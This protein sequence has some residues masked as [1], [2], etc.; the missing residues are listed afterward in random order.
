M[1]RPVPAVCAAL[2]FS[3]L[4]SGCVSTVGGSA[5]QAHGGGSTRAG[6]PKLEKSDLEH[7]LLT[8][9]A[10]NGIMDATGIRQTRTSEEMSDN[11][12]AVSDID[13]L[14]A[15]YGAEEKV[16]K[17][18][19]WTAVR[20]EVLQEP[21]SDNDHWVEQIAVLFP[22]PDKAQKFVEESRTTWKKCEG[23]S[24]DIDN[25]EVHSTWDIGDADTAGEIL[26]QSAEQR[27]AGG[28]GCQHALGTA[29]HLV[30]EAWACSN[31]IGDEAGSIA[32]EML[33]NAAKKK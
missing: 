25:D 31:S 2:M 7:V 6:G 22:S 27:D 14:G 3:A 9:G 15:I 12:D 21:V 28:W 33:R 24:I 26:T 19:D 8:A 1:I 32:T 29:S 5:V 11:S 16:Y 23:S 17:G 4:L 30:V 10:V 18:S 20:D 13:C